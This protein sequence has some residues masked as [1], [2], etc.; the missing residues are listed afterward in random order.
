MSWP[1]FPPKLSFCW[2]D[3]WSSWGLI[4]T[5]TI[6]RLT[7]CWG[8][9]LR[10]VRIRVR[11]PIRFRCW[12][13]SILVERSFWISALGMLLFVYNF[14]VCLIDWFN[15]KYKMFIDK[16][17]LSGFFF[18][19]VWEF[20]GLVWLILFWFL[21]LKMINN[22]RIKFFCRDSEVSRVF[23]FCLDLNGSLI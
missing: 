23:A 18:L 20:L 7:N 5:R 15:Y 11:Y 19:S 6:W 4:Y 8:F 14:V 1:A 22:I 12:F 10:F 17:V 3:H 2:P 9:I 13:L 16:K 21:I